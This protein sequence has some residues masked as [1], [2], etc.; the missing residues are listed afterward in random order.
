MCHDI[1]N[2]PLVT[3]AGALP[4]C[5]RQGPEERFETLRFVVKHLGTVRIGVHHSSSLADLSPVYDTRLLYFGEY[6][7]NS[8]LAMVGCCLAN[9]AAKISI[10]CCPSWS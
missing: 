10:A 2:L 8:H 4:I 9:K 6:R 5:W 1:G 3:A 7:M